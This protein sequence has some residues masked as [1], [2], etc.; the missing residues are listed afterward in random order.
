MNVKGIILLLFLYSAFQAIL[1]G[2]VF[3]L[4]KGNR[5]ANRLFSFFM[6]LFSFHL[7]FNFLHWKGYTA[8]PVLI[9]LVDI[10]P[11]TWLLYGPLLYLY[12]ESV[13]NER[14]ISTKDLLHLIPV[15]IFY[16]I[17]WRCLW[18]PEAEKIRILPQND[19]D[20]CYPNYT[21]LI[22]SAALI[23]YVFRLY[24]LLFRKSKLSNSM[25]IWAKWI[26]SSFASYVAVLTLVFFCIS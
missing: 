6:F 2:I 20:P 21:V 23:F 1:L 22:I 14:R 19:A 12:F 13:I 11:I 5:Y 7:L 24:V 16:A 9:H 26:F 18:I 4:K 3:L 8:S 15:A 10:K 17:V 25:R